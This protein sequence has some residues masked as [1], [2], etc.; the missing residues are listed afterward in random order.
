MTTDDLPNA[1]IESAAVGFTRPGTAQAL[2]EPFVETYHAAIDG[3]LG[4]GSPT[5]VEGILRGFYPRGLAD[6]R[7]ADATQ[8]WLDSH[9]DAPDAIRRIMIENRDPIVRALAAQ[10]RDGRD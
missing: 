4:H 8:A 10:E 1:I 9:P 6:Q 5:I 7:L 3:L 2:L